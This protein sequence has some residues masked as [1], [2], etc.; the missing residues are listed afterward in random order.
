MDRNSTVCERGHGLPAKGERPAGAVERRDRDGVAGKERKDAPETSKVCCDEA[1][2]TGHVERVSFLLLPVRQVGYDERRLRSQ[3][4]I[5]RQEFITDRFKVAATHPHGLH[6]PVLG[7]F[8]GRSRP[9]VKSGALPITSKKTARN[10][11][12]QRGER[13]RETGE[14]RETCVLWWLMLLLLLFFGGGLKVF[15]EGADVCTGCLDRLGC[16]VR[17]NKENLIAV[18]SLLPVSCVLVRDGVGC[19]CWR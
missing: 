7:S 1:R 11:Q 3:H 16:N 8:W 17:S 15:E 6:G 2:P 9:V 14:E 10:V 19:W 13:E 18:L 4:A 5:A 12:R